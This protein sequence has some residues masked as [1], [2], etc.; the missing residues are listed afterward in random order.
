MN[1]I[2]RIRKWL[3]W[4]LILAI[5]LN[6]VA[7]ALLAP[8]IVQ[9]KETVPLSV[10]TAAIGYFIRRRALDP[11]LFGIA[12]LIAEFTSEHTVGPQ[13]LCVLTL[14]ALAISGRPR[15]ALFLGIA[16]LSILTLAINLKFMFAGSILTLQDL[17]YFALE[18]HDNI[19]VMASQPTLVAYIS[20][21]AIAFPMLSIWLWRQDSW[22]TEAHIT[23][24]GRTEWIVKGFAALGALWCTA[25]LSQAATVASA[26]SAWD[27]G[28]TD[29]PISTFFSTLYLDAKPSYHK[30]DTADFSDRVKVLQSVDKTSKDLP[31][32]IVFLQESQFNLHS[33]AK[34]PITICNLDVFNSRDTTTDLGELRVHTFGGGTWLSEFAL[35]TGLPHSLFGRAGDYVPFNVAP[36][37]E[38]SFV[39]SLKAAGYYTVVVYPVGGGMVNARQAYKAYGFDEFLDKNDLGLGDGFANTD[40]RMHQAAVRVLHSARRHGKPVYLMAVTIFNH[41]QHGVRMDRVPNEMQRAAEKVFDDPAESRNLADY[42]WRTDEFGKAYSR[43]RDE[44]IGSDRRS[45]LAWFGDHQPPFAKAPRLLASIQ[46]RFPRS[47]ILNGFFTWYNIESNFQP[48]AAG[49]VPNQLDIAFLPGL[50]AQRGGVPLDDWLAANVVARDKCGGLVIECVEPTWRDAYYT[51]LLDDLKV[52]R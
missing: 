30:V 52:I 32:I 47:N 12:I 37:V 40:S 45:I 49:A 35:A 27:F 11:L 42:V 23:H 51:Y 3:H 21:T 29:Q 43:T 1:N 50:L 14:G 8:W 7:I 9:N 16:G 31:D 19:G 17:H 34:C 41:S 22:T 24:S 38:R 39:R 48:G 5:L 18:F 26:T 46:S 20:V 28:R 2:T 25:A 10:A 15:F 36:R 13:V 6:V 4:K 44:I 33:I